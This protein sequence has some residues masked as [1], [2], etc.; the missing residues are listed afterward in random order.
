MSLLFILSIGSIALATASVIFLI[1]YV[2]EWTQ[3]IKEE[4]DHEAKW[5]QIL[6]D[7]EHRMEQ[8]E[9]AVALEKEW[10][11]QFIRNHPQLS[12]DTKRILL[13][14]L[15]DNKHRTKLPFETEQS[16]G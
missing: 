16:N 3:R 11:D 8:V 4:K 2:R 15:K 9:E 12:E 14:E 10:T 1:L 13:Q 5:V 6:R 7:Y